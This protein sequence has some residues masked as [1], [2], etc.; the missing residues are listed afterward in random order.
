MNVILFSKKGYRCRHEV[1]TLA[2]YKRTYSPSLFECQQFMSV[3]QFLY[4]L[5]ARYA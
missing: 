2:A 5:V 1:I 4:V 3:V